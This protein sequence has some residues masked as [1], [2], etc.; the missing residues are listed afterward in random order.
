M[1]VPGPRAEATPV[2]AFD[3]PSWVGE[4]D[5]VWT[6]EV[7]LGT[8]MVTGRL[9]TREGP[10]D[11]E[12]ACDLLACDRAYPEP[13][14]PEQWRREAHSQWALQQVLLLEIDGRLTLV[15]PGVDVSV[16]TAMESLRRLA[17]AVGVPASRFTLALRL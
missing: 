16:E 10:D 2:D 14:L 13:A 11:P 12:L 5:V 4:Q 15:A 3:L 7:S 9:A 1:R 6:S 8:P 17:K